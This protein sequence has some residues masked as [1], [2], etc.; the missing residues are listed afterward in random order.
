ME[1]ILY[2][3]VGCWYLSEKDSGSNSSGATQVLSRLVLSTSTIYNANPFLGIATVPVS[4]Y[5][6]G[7]KKKKFY[8]MSKF[9]GY[10]LSTP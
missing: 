6:R 4:F 5:F 1:L 10:P 3:N 7:K 9:V 2:L 8:C